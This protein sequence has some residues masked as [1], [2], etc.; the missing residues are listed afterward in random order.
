MCRTVDIVHSAMAVYGF[1]INYKRTKTAILPTLHGAGA[2][3]VKQQLFSTTEPHIITKKYNIK[4][5]IETKYKHLGTHIDKDGCIGTQ[6]A[7][8]L[9][10]QKQA[11][12]PV[13]KSIN[14][15]N[16]MKCESKLRIADAYANVHLGYHSETWPAPSNKQIDTLEAAQ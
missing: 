1:E 6:I 8:N 15:L 9:Q 5:F 12:G 10:K 14:K 3:L 7:R 4:V 13:R 11:L 16:M 2:N